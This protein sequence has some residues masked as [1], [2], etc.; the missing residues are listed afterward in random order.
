[1]KELF[2]CY[3]FSDHTLNWAEARDYCAGLGGYLFEAGDMHE[4]ELVAAIYGE[5]KKATND[6]R[7][8]LDYVTLF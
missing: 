4:M 8:I 2:S 3:E 5:T 1:M 6:Q 7:F